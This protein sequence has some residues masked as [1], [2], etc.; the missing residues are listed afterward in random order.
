MQAWFN[1]YAVLGTSAAALMGLLFVATSLNAAAA[2]TGGPQGLRGL[3]QQ[4]F[5]N[6]L[7]VLMVSLLALFPD[8]A[9]GH[10]RPGNAAGHRHLERLG[11]RALVP[12]CGPA[13]RP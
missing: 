8:M 4:A 10:L 7:A 2:L 3:T 1:F 9:S 5:E 6:Y 13:L 11:D 12:D